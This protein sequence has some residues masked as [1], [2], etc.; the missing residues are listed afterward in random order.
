[1]SKIEAID[2]YRNGNAGTYDAMGQGAIQLLESITPAD[3]GQAVPYLQ[4]WQI[5]PTTGL[6]I[7]GT[8]PNNSIPAYPLTAWTVAPPSFGSS[9]D[10]F[11]EL[12]ERPAVS[13][14]S[15]TIKT[16]NP[17]GLMLYRQLDINFIVHRPDVLAA[18]PV[19]GRDTWAALITPGSIMA[20]EYGWSANIGHVKNP[21][22]N[23]TGVEGSS[24]GRKW[25]VNGQK[26]IRFA[27]TNYKF[28][29]LP[30]QQIKISVSAIEDGD[31]GIR[32]TYVVEGAGPKPAPGDGDKLINYDPGS[33]KSDFTKKA[34]ALTQK[35]KKELAARAYANKSVGKVIRIEDVFDIF[36]AS[37][38]EESIKKLGYKS[39]TFR[40]GCVNEKCPTPRTK[41][42]PQKPKKGS[43][44]AKYIGD[45]TIPLQDVVD[46][47]TTMIANG[48]QLTAFNFITPF[49]RI[50]SDPTIWT[51]EENKD[52]TMPDIQIRFD[53][54]K[55]DDGRQSATVHV[56]DMKTELMR[57]TKTDYDSYQ[58]W[59][60]ENSTSAS[61]VANRD[62][63]RQ[64]C[65]DKGIPYVE[66][67]KGNSWIKD[68]QFDVV[69]DE[70]IQA[71]FINRYYGQDREATVSKT[72]AEL[73]DKT[74]DHRK[75]LYSSAIKGQ[76]TCVG[77]HGM[78]VMGMYWVDFG[79]PFW[80]GPYRLTERTD[81]IDASGWWTTIQLIAE[82][83][84]PLG[85][86]DR[87]KDDLKKAAQPSK[88][89]KKTDYSKQGT[90]STL[91]IMGPTIL[92]KY[93]LMRGAS[94]I[95]EFDTYE[96]ANNV[97][98]RMRS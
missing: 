75:T 72:E 63:I 62:K 53:S 42:S 5:S 39:V 74:V 58:K 69:T 52:V 82:G 55:D 61:N 29:L 20:M 68:A 18:D 14:E 77:N 64:I 6:P 85:T 24:G 10:E 17:M 84:D 40:M 1:M 96:D 95:G 57:F 94:K 28:V 89:T 19:K 21:I 67:M 49:L 16:V 41:H 56:I 15:V 7:N 35:L 86:Q 25:T 97:K 11:A 31:F 88:A 36:F 43:T 8:G 23:G 76:L 38:V 51:N 2:T 48:T 79:I 46:R 26:I 91:H 4:M 32:H 66:F 87:P 54:I 50:L 73:R 44:P 12:R 71:I 78:D 60:K 9:I 59:C 70:L 83:S 37:R 81:Q 45:F 13:L 98:M 22:L 33:Q 93:L 27:V 30:D 34:K 80:S 47:M 90:I 65:V 92:G 3:M